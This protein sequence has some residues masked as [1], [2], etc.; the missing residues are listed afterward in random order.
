VYRRFEDGNFRLVQSRFEM[1]RL[2]EVPLS[3]QLADESVTAAI[4]FSDPT[5]A[6][7]LLPLESLQSPLAN[8]SL[9][10]GQQISAVG[11]AAAIAVPVDQLTLQYSEVGVDGEVVALLQGLLPLTHANSSAVH[12]SVLSTVTV[13]REGQVN[14]SAIDPSSVQQPDLQRVVSEVLGEDSLLFAPVNLPGIA[15]VADTDS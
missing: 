4:P 10:D 15:S 12:M 8:I 3:D 1:D 6:S 2:L 9:Q 13:D 7:S 14:T 5:E 11:A